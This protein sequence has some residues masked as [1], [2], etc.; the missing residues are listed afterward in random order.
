MY[1]GLH[2]ANFH[3][4]T[5]SDLYAAG[6]C[7]GICSTSYPYQVVATG[8]ATI[9]TPY[10]QGKNKH[11]QHFDLHSFAAGCMAVTPGGSPQ[12]TPPQPASC[13]ITL[14]GQHDYAAH[15][16][17]QKLPPPVYTIASFNYTLGASPDGVA[18]NTSAPMD[19]F[20]L[21]AEFYHMREIEFS[22]ELIEDGFEE[23]LS[24][25]AR[26]FAPTRG[27]ELHPERYAQ[28]MIAELHIDD[29]KFEIDD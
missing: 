22:A 26:E 27:T 1:K 2:R 14:R 17:I 13:K 25:E 16:R 18:A 29:V 3:L 11:V 15:L 5:Y 28:R 23:P 24:E 4:P 8:P 9:S 7:Y 10:R 12:S 6:D 21:S 20:T 19:K